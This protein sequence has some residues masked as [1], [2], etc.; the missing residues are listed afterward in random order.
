MNANDIIREV[1]KSASEWIE[2]SHDP[3]T[4]VAGILANKIIALTNHIEYLEKRLNHDSC[5]T[6]GHRARN[7]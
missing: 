2:M 7:S 4:L 1:E 6:G 5:N 3:A